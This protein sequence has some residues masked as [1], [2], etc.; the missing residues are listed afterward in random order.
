MT[1]LAAGH[2]RDRATGEHDSPMSTARKHCGGRLRSPAL[3]LKRTIG[4]WSAGAAFQ[5]G[6]KFGIGRC[7]GMEKTTL[8]SLTSEERRTRPHIGRT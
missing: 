4:S 8:I 7:S 6:A 3:A 5:L 2:C 1:R